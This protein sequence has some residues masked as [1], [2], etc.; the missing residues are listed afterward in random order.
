MQIQKYIWVKQDFSFQVDSIMATN[1]Q[2]NNDGER[3]MDK[4]CPNSLDHNIHMKTILLNDH[5]K[6]FLQ[7]HNIYNGKSSFPYIRQITDFTA[8]L[9]NLNKVKLP[10]R[11]SVLKS[12]IDLEVQNALQK[13]GTLNWWNGSELLLLKT[14]SKFINICLIFLFQSFS[15]I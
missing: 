5:L 9:P 8:V 10:A 4:E 14:T 3:K 7:V 12:V 11:N 2:G 15:L 13:S 6:E 1:Y